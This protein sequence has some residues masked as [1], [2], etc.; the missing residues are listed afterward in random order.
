MKIVVLPDDF[1]SFAVSDSLDDGCVVLLVGKVNHILEYFS[2]CVDSS[3]IS[4]KT[5]TQ[6]NCFLLCMQVS[7]FSLQLSVVDTAAT[8]V[9]STTSTNSSFLD[10]LDNGVLN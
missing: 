6:D 5:T 1:I 4:D 9:T 8:D 2:Q 7:Q 10:C 3:L